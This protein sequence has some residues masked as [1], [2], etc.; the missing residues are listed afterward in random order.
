M[1]KTLAAGSAAAVAIAAAVLLLFPGAG[2][3]VQCVVIEQ[4]EDG[5]LSQVD[6]ELCG[7]APKDPKALPNVVNVVK[8]S[9]PYPQD[10]SPISTVA[11]EA[12]EAPTKEGDPA[13]TVAKT[14][15]KDGPDGGVIAGVTKLSPSA[16]GC[17][18]ADQRKDSLLCEQYDA[19]GAKW[20]TA[21]KATVMQPGQWRGAGC[22]ASVCFETYVR[23]TLAGPGSQIRPECRK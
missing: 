21:P 4:A 12:K 18:C 15:V 22:V 6:I 10:H 7:E 23:E 1:K 3:C 16:T 5:K 11:P 20:I 19:K 8:C 13:A 9:D 14:P 17:A 2:K